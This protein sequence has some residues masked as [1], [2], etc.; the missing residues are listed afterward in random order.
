MY[1]PSREYS[2]PSSS[3]LAVVRR[4]SSPPAAGIVYISKSPSRCPTKARVL[5]SGDHPCQY[6]GDF[7]VILHGVPPA[8]GTIYTRE[9]PSPC[10]LSLMASHC[11]SG[12][13]PWSLL[14]RVANP[15]SIT[16]GVPP[17][18]LSLSMRP[19]RLNRNAVPSSVQL[20][21]SKRPGATYTTRRFVEA[22]VTVSSVLKSFAA[23]AGGGNSLTSTLEKM[24]FSVTS[25]SCEQTPIPT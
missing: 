22:I 25:L 17:L 15:V 24:A 1:F 6:E 18:T 14:Q 10:E 7:S 2:G 21:A 16:S 23:P 19:F 5:P 3:P 11:A 20:G 9:P 8:M 13:I 12:E 4:V